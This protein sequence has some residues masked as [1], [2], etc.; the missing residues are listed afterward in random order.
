NKQYNTPMTIGNGQAFNVTL[1]TGSSDL[2]LPG[3]HCTSADGS[4]RLPLI[5]G[6]DKTL[7][8]TGAPYS[9]SYAGGSFANGT[10]F[11]GPLSL[12]GASTK[13][14][15]FLASDEITSWGDPESA[16][17]LGLGF[18]FA[19]EAMVDVLKGAK[20]PI[21]A[22]GL[23]SFGI[24]L[25]N[26]VEG[27]RGVFTTNGV[28]EAHVGGPFSYVPIVST[29][30]AWT[31]PFVDATFAV[32]GKTGPI[33][34]ITTVDTGMDIV[35]LPTAVA[36]GIW[37]GIGAVPLADGSNQATIDCRIAATGPDVHLTFSGTTYTIPASYYVYSGDVT[38]GCIAGFMGG[39]EL[40]GNSIL[41]D[42]FIRAHYSHFDITNK[43]IGELP[44]IC[45]PGFL[46][47]R[48]CSHSP[49]PPRQV[50]Q[51]LSTLSRGPTTPRQFL[52]FFLLGG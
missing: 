23:S 26:L 51:R 22:L 36:E 35:V 45:A 16:G 46:L 12:G 50:S 7:I 9:L 42:V 4:C 44:F 27:D 31:I 41:G 17:F 20:T 19:Q 33:T 30:G 29:T 8:P 1:D 47:L 13:N 11:R 37:A 25:S 24:Y 15:F 28:D 6:K 32:N 34:G 14:G 39:A 18:P 38:S 48:K 21:Q 10:I 52:L 43:R 3:P 49:P 40:F 2:F 5:D